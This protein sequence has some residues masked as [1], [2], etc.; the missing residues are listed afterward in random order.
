M[1]TESVPAIIFT[2]QKSQV[3]LK[4][5]VQDTLGYSKCA[6]KHMAGDSSLIPISNGGEE[7]FHAA[8]PTCPSFT[9]KGSKGSGRGDLKCTEQP[10]HRSAGW[11][12]TG[13][14]IGQDRQTEQTKTP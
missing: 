2:L 4:D 8:A 13:E 11:W 14:S 10:E 5:R 9:S 1:Q 7:A 6:E 3:P 12:E